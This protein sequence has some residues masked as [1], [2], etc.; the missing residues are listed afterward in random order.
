GPGD[1]ESHAIRAIEEGSS[2]L[3]GA[4]GHSSPSLR[5]GGVVHG[6]IV[7]RE[8]LSWLAWGDRA[9]DDSPAT[10][11][12]ADSAWLRNRHERQ[13]ATSRRASSGRSRAT[14]DD[15]SIASRSSALSR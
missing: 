1:L 8:W 6:L 2:M 5:E 7:H 14:S 9:W 12:R 4:V 11:T 15:P 10:R 13:T 3:E